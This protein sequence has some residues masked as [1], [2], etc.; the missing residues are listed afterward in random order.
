MLSSSR[1]IGCCLFSFV[2][3]FLAL[4]CTQPRVTLLILELTPTFRFYL[5]CFVLLNT[6][7]PKNHSLKPLKHRSKQWNSPQ[8]P[9]T[10]DWT[11]CYVDKARFKC[12]KLFIGW[13]FINE[14]TRFHNFVA[15]RIAVIREVSD[16]TQWIHVTTDLNPGDVASRGKS[17]QAFEKKDKWLN[18][19]GF[20]WKSVGEWPSELLNYQTIRKDVPE[21]KAET[22]LNAVILDESIVTLNKW[23]MHFSNWHILKKCTAWIL[24]LREILGNGV[25]FVWNHVKKRRRE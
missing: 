15:N 8:P 9:S 21:V 24:G 5:S 14:T 4:C 3:T 22:A 19:P 18:G 16:P 17:I 25:F 12:V 1:S 2:S 7:T 23:I 10:C 13:Y 11:R 20:F 6:S